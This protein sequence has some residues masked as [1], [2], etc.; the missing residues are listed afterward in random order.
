MSLWLPVAIY[1]A[2]IFYVSSLHQPPLP[3]GVSD[4]PAHA[5][6]YL[7]FGL[8]IARALAGGLPPRITLRQ[9]LVGLALASLYGITDELH[10]HFVPGR[11]A[12]IADWYS[13]S[14]GSAIALFGCWAW[15][16]IFARRGF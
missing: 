5:F 10:Q 14:I 4:K 13:D 8:V 3:P 12:D 1:M 15:S 11:T 7:G 6:G 16:I 9:A 2:V